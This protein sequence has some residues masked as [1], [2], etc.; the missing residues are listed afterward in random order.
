[1]VGEEE[2]TGWREGEGKW[3][4]SVTG[5]TRA[6]KAM[7]ARPGSLY[8]HPIRRRT[9]NGRSHNEITI[10]SPPRRPHPVGPLFKLRLQTPKNSLYLCFVLLSPSH[11]IYLAC[12]SCH[13]RSTLPPRLCR[14]ATLL[15]P[16]SSVE[17]QPGW[18]SF[19]VASLPP[20]LVTLFQSVHIPATHDESL[21]NIRL[22]QFRILS[23]TVTS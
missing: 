2:A 15:S 18:H 6:G 5:E 21:R 13:P 10:S 7:E 11:D 17:Q 12:T 22:F 1:M 8:S 20:A 16:P 9:S 3:R 23:S 19:L 4:G 14:A